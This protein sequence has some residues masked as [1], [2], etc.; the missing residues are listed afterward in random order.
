MKDRRFYNRRRAIAIHLLV[1][2]LAGLISLLALRFVPPA[3]HV[4]GPTTV[5][6]G[7][8]F[9]TGDTILF[10]PPLGTVVAN[11]HFSPL[12]LRLT[13]TSVDPDSLADAVSVTSRDLLVDQLENDLRGTAARLAVQ[14]ILGAVVLGLL[15]AALFPRRRLGTIVAGGIGG[16][17]IVGLI[18]LLTA[19]TFDVASFAQPRFTGALERAPQVIDALALTRLQAPSSPLRDCDPGIR[20]PRRDCRTFWP[21]LPM[22]HPIRKRTASRSCT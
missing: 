6:A 18:V 16:G 4:L 5:S 15:I 19:R 3:S 22:R 2:S 12:S 10:I 20:L 11:T 17:I 13:I 1:G 14:L 9:G 21:S 8:S 7:G